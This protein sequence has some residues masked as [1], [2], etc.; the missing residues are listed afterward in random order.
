MVLTSQPV[1][2]VVT[3]QSDMG[4]G[5]TISVYLPRCASQHEREPPGALAAP[6]EAPGR[7]A[8]TVLVVEDDPHFAKVAVSLVESLGYPVVYARSGPAALTV[9]DEGASVDILLSDVVLPEGMTGPELARRVR[10]A[11][12]G[13]HVIFMSGYP[14]DAMGSLGPQERLIAKPFRR[15][16]LKEALEQASASSQVLAPR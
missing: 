8:E 1:T 13:V 9:I 11:R 10:E 15:P 4:S 6:A 5:T 12:P 2:A 14:S 7:R 3:I 16:E